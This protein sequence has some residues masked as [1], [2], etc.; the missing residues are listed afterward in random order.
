MVQDF[1][2]TFVYESGIKA[3][4]IKQ[5][6]KDAYNESKFLNKEN[7]LSFIKETMETIL[8]ITEGSKTCAEKFILSKYISFDKYVEDL[9]D[10]DLTEDLMSTSFSPS[11]KPEV[12]P[13]AKVLDVGPSDEDTEE[14]KENKKQQELI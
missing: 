4:I 8:D 12:G 10:C 2:E 13:D 7:D 3:S 1:L 5:V 9:I 6:Y 11:V 14:N